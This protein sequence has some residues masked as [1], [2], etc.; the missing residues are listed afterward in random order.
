MWYNGITHG[1]GSCNPGPTPGIPTKDILFS[2]L[3]QSAEGA[4]GKAQFYAVNAFGLKIDLEFAA[5]GDIGMAA[6][7]A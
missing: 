3:R 6:G 2:N 4:R 7:I 5:A 1:W